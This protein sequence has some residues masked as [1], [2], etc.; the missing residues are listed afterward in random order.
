MLHSQLTQCHDNFQ[1]KTLL[2]REYYK[3][4]NGFI[5]ISLST[6]YNVSFKHQ[7]KEDIMMRNLMSSFHSPVSMPASL[8]ENGVHTINIFMDE[9]CTQDTIAFE[10]NI[11]YISNLEIS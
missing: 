4:N 5:G 11:F 2:C 3:S 9:I 1:A 6:L 10:E 8:F 7:L